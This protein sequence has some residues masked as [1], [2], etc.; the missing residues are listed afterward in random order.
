MTLYIGVDLSGPSNTKDTS[1]AIFSGNQ[2]EMHFKELM[3]GASDHDIYRRVENE[4]EVMVIGID[5][6]LSY[7]PGGGDRPGDRAMRNCIKEAGMKSGS[8]MTPTMTRMVY[9]TLR[10]ISLS[11][12]LATTS[13]SIVEVHPGA[14]V[15]LRLSDI[16]SVLTYKFDI[17]ARKA[18]HTFLENERVI[19]IPE[20]TL[21][22][23]HSFDACLAAYAAWK[24]HHG[25]ASFSFPPEPPIH[26]FEISC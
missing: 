16:N 22:S 5:A 14:A 6:P 1:V 17:A 19:D 15:G 10:G 23:T 18:I 25:K 26:P 7:Q 3:E 8:I 2:E 4:Q 13:A 11:R 21:Q 9:L 12:G 20:H 24:W